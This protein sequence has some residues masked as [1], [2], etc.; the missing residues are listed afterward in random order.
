MT[1]GS[2]KTLGLVGTRIMIG[3][4]IPEKVRMG[5]GNRYAIPPQDI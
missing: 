5:I 4:D 1:E 3:M 2:S